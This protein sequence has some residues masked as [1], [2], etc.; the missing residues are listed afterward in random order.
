MYSIY[1][2]AL[3]NVLMIDPPPLSTSSP[4][5]IVARSDEPQLPPHIDISAICFTSDW[6]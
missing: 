4:E 2:E 5:N 3:T 1:F 6:N